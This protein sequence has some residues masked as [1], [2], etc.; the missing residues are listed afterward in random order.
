MFS[1][2]I[3][4]EM[5]KNYSFQCYLIP[6][7]CCQSFKSF[8][9]EARARGKMKIHLQ[10]HI[11]ELDAEADGSYIFLLIVVLYKNII[12]NPFTG[13]LITQ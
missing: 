8:G 2:L 10:A 1:E 7:K 13:N 3:C 12:L 9:N 4:D 11:R 6:D 5:K